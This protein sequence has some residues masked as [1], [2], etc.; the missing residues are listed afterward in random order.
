MVRK[1]PAMILII[2]GIP[3]RRAY[4]ESTFILNGLVEFVTVFIQ[5]GTFVKRAKPMQISTPVGMKY[6]GE[7]F[8]A[9]YSAKKPINDPVIAPETID[10]TIPMI[11]AKNI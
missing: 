10:G 8:L 3:T 6:F 4:C 9:I 1:I 2:L 11:S 7:Y 5:T